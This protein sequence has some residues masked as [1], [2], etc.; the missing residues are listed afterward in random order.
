MVDLS[1]RSELATAGR[2]AKRKGKA[3]SERENI[4]SD[5]TCK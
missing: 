5:S 4:D 2:Q 1:P 3:N